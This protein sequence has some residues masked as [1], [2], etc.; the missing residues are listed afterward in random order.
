MRPQRRRRGD[1]VA[2][3]SIVVVVVVT[4]T[5]L[6]RSSDAAGTSSVQAD[7][8]VA[9]PPAATSVPDRF[10]E[11]W[12]APSAAT[13][14]PV[15]TASA[16][17]TADGSTVVGRD[18]R[19][20]AQ[21]WSYR[22]D[23]PLCTVAAGFPAAESAR[24]RVLALHQRGEWCSEMVS[25]RPDTGE[26]AATRNPD[27]RPGTR[28]TGAGTLLTA[29][30]AE[31]LEVMRSDL[32]RTLEYGTVATP[33]QP[34]QQPRSGCRFG[35][36][37]MA[38]GRLGVLMT[39]PDEDTDRLTVVDPDGTEGADTP[40][41]TFSVPVA[42]GA[43]LVALS[44]ERA[45]VA[46]PDGTGLQLHDSAGEVI[47]TTP[48]DVDVDAPQDGLAAVAGD[49]DRLYWWTGSQ[50]V[51]L[52]RADLTP[53]WTMT[54]PTLGPPADYADMLLVPVPGGLQPL[55]PQ[56]GRAAELIP[57]TR[58]DPAAPV[59]LAAVGEVLL[60]QRGAVLVALS[61]SR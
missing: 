46:L 14:L 56:S 3:A 27:V 9:A 59:R 54:E 6:W 17:V 36:V 1:V 32:V 24:G 5:L 11:A 53:I 42:P 37:A 4:A 40:Q 2:A 41:E 60:E 8:P 33:A 15:A 58:D 55:D 19:T 28:L 49:D 21:R 12:R 18:A 45:A 13:P 31:Y 10:I 48:L 44:A 43:V 20:G 50:V 47:A 39:C 35:S 52:D 34:D 51:A 29:T 23:L 22:R 16:A 30:G 61:P 38:Q 26:R 57:L 7:P 25:L